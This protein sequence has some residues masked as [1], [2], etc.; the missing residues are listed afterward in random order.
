MLFVEYVNRKRIAKAEQLLVTTRDSVTEIALAV[1]IGNMAHFY[2]L[3]K[4]YNR[5]TPKQFLHKMGVAGDV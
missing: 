4:R 5:C 1:G 3:F 2:E